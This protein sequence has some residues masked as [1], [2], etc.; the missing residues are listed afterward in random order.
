ARCDAQPYF[1]KA[2]AIAGA[3]RAASAAVSGTR[4]QTRMCATRRSGTACARCEATPICSLC[5]DASRSNGWITTQLLTTRTQTQ[6]ARVTHA[7]RCND[8][9]DRVLAALPIARHGRIGNRVM[10]GG[11]AGRIFD[12]ARRGRHQ[13]RG[14][15]RARTH[16]RP[17]DDRGH[18]LAVEFDAVG[19]VLDDELCHGGSR[20]EVGRPAT[21]MVRPPLGCVVLHSV[22]SS[23]YEYR[24]SACELRGSRSRDDVAAVG[25][26]AP[27]LL[28]VVTPPRW[29]CP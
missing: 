2:Y 20:N 6:T 24:K 26:P 15:S 21:V 22:V 29:W 7:C 16:A 11:K 12:D 10:C 3:A 13:R 25:D 17:A 23:H 9:P 27:A 19:Q 28:P 5:P 8:E 14:A 4:V 18:C 1:C